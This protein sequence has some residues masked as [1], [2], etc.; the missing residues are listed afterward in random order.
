LAGETLYNLTKIF[1][2]VEVRMEYSPALSVSSNTSDMTDEELDQYFA[3]YVP[4]SSLPTPPPAKSVTIRSTVE[5]TTA[6][7][8]AKT[9]E[10]EGRF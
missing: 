3:S 1:P 9:P 10:L 8:R 2:L 7:I 6:V 5:D 4:L